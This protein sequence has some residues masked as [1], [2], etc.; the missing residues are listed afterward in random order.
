MFAQHADDAVDISRFA[1]MMVE[2]TA[3]SNLREARQVARHHNQERRSVSVC[4]TQSERQG[5]T[6]E[7]RHLQI[8]DRHVR[9]LSE[10]KVKRRRSPMGHAHGRF[11]KKKL[12][13]PSKKV[14]RVGVIVS[15]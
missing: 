5:V 6:V 14:C 11:W 1:E 15:N 12:Q 13:Q 9:A 3:G 7:A 2:R 4:C 8:E 10:R